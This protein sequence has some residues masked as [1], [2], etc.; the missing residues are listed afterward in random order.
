VS[1]T[2]TFIWTVGFTAGSLFPVLSR[3]SKYMIGSIAGVFWLSSAVC[4]LAFVFGLKL[5]PETRG[6][7]LEEIADSWQRK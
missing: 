6:R 1:I 3:L 4:V 7:T 2:T 5:L